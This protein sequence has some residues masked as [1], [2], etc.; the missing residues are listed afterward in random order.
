MG[1]VQSSV[2]AKNPIEQGAGVSV[3][4]VSDYAAGGTKGWDDI[5]T[6]V[7]A[8]AK[9]DFGE[10]AEFLLVE[11]ERFRSEFPSELTSALP[12][13]KIHFLPDFTSYALKNE[14]VRMASGEYVAILDADCIPEP[15][16]L[17]RLIG[18]LRSHSKAAAV[19]G[20]TIYPNQT[21]S[22][23]VCALLARSYL[24]PGFAGRTRFI[25]INTCAFRREAYLSHPLPTDIGTFSSALQSEA[26]LRDNWDLLF[27]PDIQVI[28]DFEGWG[29]EADVR[30]NAGHGTIATRLK[31]PAM[32]WARLVRLGPGSIPV[33]LAGKIF[34]S[35][36]DCVRS[37]RSYGIRWS[38]LPAAMFI[39]IAVH[40]LEVPGMLQA[41]RGRW[42]KSSFFR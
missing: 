7:A 32:P 3:I 27:D 19:S 22:S 24:D 21:F 6:A 11:S 20:K 30:R 37:G 31:E 8:L 36:K 4:V 33:I 35:W 13:L 9:Q 41:Y 18:T 23:R 16:W 14:A 26:L 2:V 38:Q 17:R 10:P 34:N 15:S 28:H 29:M 25:A 40:L 42:L 1:L 39:S 5:R 12:E